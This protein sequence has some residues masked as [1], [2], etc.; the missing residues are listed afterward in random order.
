MRS[1]DKCLMDCIPMQGHSMR[2]IHDK[3]SNCVATKKRAGTERRAH[4]VYG[5]RSRKQNLM[6]SR[7][8]IF[9]FYDKM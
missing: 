7:F 6:K 3:G 9:L 2:T 8:L 4:R 1:D 5:F